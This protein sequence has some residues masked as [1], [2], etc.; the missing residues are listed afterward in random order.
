MWCC[1]CEDSQ[2]LRRH[3]VAWENDVI[4]QG[5]LWQGETHQAD[6]IRTW[7]FLDELG[8]SP[9]GHPLRDNLQRVCCDADKRD[10]IQVS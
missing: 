3:P 1:L 7:I 9:V 6:P 10:D 4:G 5:L 8:Q 2:D